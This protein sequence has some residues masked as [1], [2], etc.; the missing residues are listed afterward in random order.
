MN[1]CVI[2]PDVTR[3]G[4]S[5]S[6]ILQFA[7]CFKE[8]GHNVKVHS[9][10]KN[11]FPN[12]LIKDQKDVISFYNCKFLEYD[13]FIWDMDIL[14]KEYDLCF[15]RGQL[16][17]L[18]NGIPSIIWLIISSEIPKGNNITF[19][20][21]SNT[22]LSK[23]SKTIHNRTE[24]IYPPHNYSIFRNN[25]M[26][27]NEYD[28]VSI[29]RGNDF[30]DK[31]IHI[32]AD[33]IKKLN[34]KSLLITT[35][36]RDS[37]LSRIKDLNIPY[38]LNQTREQVA[39]ILGKSK[40]FFFPSLYESCPLVIYEALNSGCNIVSRDVGAVKEQL[41]SVGRT[42]KKDDQ[43]ENI[44]NYCLNTEYEK[45]TSINRGLL[46]D[47]CVIKHKIKDILDKYNDNIS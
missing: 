26:D 29:L 46:F 28:I 45:Q 22:T 39:Q 40:I 3:I 23:L 47:R 9:T 27:Y 17:K 36:P 34:C 18:T 21:N 24:V 4:G 30:Y 12:K 35:A 5:I 7:D 32:Y 33:I 37:D 11:R 43:C 31:G 41:G 10:F 25:C 38:V 8:L 1:I 16:Y 20:T 19:W 13:D 42:F 44:L 14:N 2:Q 6:T 15:T